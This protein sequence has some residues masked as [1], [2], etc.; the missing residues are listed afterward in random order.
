M[1][2]DIEHWR[3]VLDSELW[4][5]KQ[6]KEEIL[7]ALRLSYIYLPFRLKRCFS[8][9]A[10]YPKDHVFQMEVAVHIWCAQGFV[11]PQG[12]IPLSDIARSYFQELIDRSLFQEAA[13]APDTYVIHDLIHDMLQLVSAN[14]SS[15]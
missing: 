8:L 6:E 12:Q 10:M 7:P 14:E 9:C 5:L 2:H 1:N 13:G 15:S 3:N 4:E 11:E